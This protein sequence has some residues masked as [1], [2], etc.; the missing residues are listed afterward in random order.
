LRE[1][2]SYVLRF[3]RRDRREFDGFGFLNISSYYVTCRY[4][5]CRYV[6]CRYV[7]CDSDWG[8]VVG[9][10]DREDFLFG[11]GYD[12]FFRT[13]DF[14]GIGNGVRICRGK[15]SIGCAHCVVV[16]AGLFFV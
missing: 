16:V 7:V 3:G 1:R 4:V 9:S 10:V 6:T 8:G 2:G 14:F 11:R 12:G 15:G 5:T 13:C